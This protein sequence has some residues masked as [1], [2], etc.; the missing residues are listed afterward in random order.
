[1]TDWDGKDRRHNLEVVDTTDVLTRD[2]VRELK[3][4]A[5][6]SR[7]AKWFFALA[8]GAVGLFG[9]DKLSE[10]VGHK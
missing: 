4:L 2:E 8:M 3:S 5:Q 9:L 10:W 7:T 1:M 6:M